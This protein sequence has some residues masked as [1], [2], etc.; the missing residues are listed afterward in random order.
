MEFSL[1]GQTYTAVRYRL[2]EWL[3]LE[4]LREELVEA[5]ETK[6]IKRTAKVLCA[7]VSV[8]TNKPI[9]DLA[10]LPWYEIVGAFLSIE[11]ENRLHY[12]FAV[13]RGG[14]TRK[15]TDDPPWEYRGRDW[16]WWAHTLSS[17]YGW[18][19]EYIAQLDI[20]DATG[21][22][23]EIMVEEQLT[24]EWQWS[25]TELAY[26]YNEQTK[27]STFKPLERPNWMM[28]VSQD[29]I[30]PLPTMKIHKSM[31]PVGIVVRGKNET[32]AN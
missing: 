18:S 30:P 22:L 8:A 2:R 20:D 17:H 25:L 9:E 28:V 29:K 1:G 3:K 19:L 13:V 10:K 6:D 7:F 24:R 21:L 26:P 14:G 11:A 4:S 5:I 32:V 12:D 15:K 23:Q 27:K 16:Y 31:I